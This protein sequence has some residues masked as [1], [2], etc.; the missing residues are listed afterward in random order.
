MKRA[1]GI[2]LSPIILAALYLG[3][4]PLQSN[5]TGMKTD[6]WLKMRMSFLPRSDVLRPI[7]LGFE[8]TY[9]NYLWFKTVNYYGTHRLTDQSYPWLTQMVDMVTQLNPYFEPA[10]EWAGLFIPDDLE[11]PGAARI[12]LNRGITHLGDRSWKV[13]FYQGLI[14]FKHYND[15]KTAAD[16][17]AMGARVPSEHSWKLGRMAA[18]FYAQAGVQTDAVSL[19]SFLIQTTESPAIREVLR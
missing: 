8:T 4:A 5:L 9:A 3:I 10:Y 18:T 13:Y 16:F 1:A 7:L 15:R 2:L 11:N 6:D 14:H 17:F 12:I 19:L